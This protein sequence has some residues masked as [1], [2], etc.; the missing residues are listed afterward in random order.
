MER[1]ELPSEIKKSVKLNNFCLPHFYPKINKFID[2]QIGYKID[3]NT[4]EK[5]TGE[6]RR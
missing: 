1:I 4:G 5:I 6:K 3:G 2:F